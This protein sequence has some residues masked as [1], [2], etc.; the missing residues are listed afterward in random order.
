MAKGYFWW[1]WPIR[2]IILRPFWWAIV[3]IV[4]FSV[5]LIRMWWWLITPI[6]LMFPLKTFYFWWI[7]WDFWYPT[8]NKWLM[9]EIVPP[10]EILTPFKAMEDVFSVIWT[11]YDDANWREKWCEGELPLAPYWFS[12]EIASIEGTIHFYIRCLDVHRHIIESVLYSH[13]PEVEITE[14]PDYT[15]NVPQNI[16]NEE[17]DVYGSDFDFMRPA[18]YPIKT[19]SRFFEPMGERI[20]KEE[21]RIDPITSL[22]EDMARIGPG[23]QVWFQIIAAPITNKEVPWIDEGKKI[24]S[25]IARRPEPKKAKSTIG[26]AGDIFRE[27]IS[28]PPTDE[29]FSLPF[30]PSKTSISPAVSEEGEREMIITPGEREILSAIEEKI[31][32]PGFKTNIRGVYVYKRDSFNTVHRKIVE[33][34]APHFYTL[35]LNLMKYF[36]ESRT[37]VH[38]I[39]RTRRTYLRKK[40]MFRNYVDRF[41]P[42]FPIITGLGNPI[43]NTEEL[44]TLYH[45]PTRIGALFVPTVTRI[46]SKKGGPPPGLPTE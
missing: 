9:L 30:F 34:Y 12:L 28:L 31:K 7:R 24:I 21:K 45:F 11:I 5:P 36:N 27:V 29:E 2:R 46:E 44:A 41:P 26:G 37:K 8:K 35:N 16:P 17:W 22:L 32:K 15:R 4:V 19:Y 43:L 42:F 33:S 1:L 40:K 13:Y 14:V 6:V 38:Y 23:E 20:A 39:W 10:R 3:L 25:K 18:A